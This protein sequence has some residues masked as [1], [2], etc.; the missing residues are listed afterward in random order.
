MTWTK[1]ALIVAA[2]VLLAGCPGAQPRYKLDRAP[3]RFALSA[4]QLTPQE[5]IGRADSIIVGE[6]KAKRLLGQT[7]ITDKGFRVRVW[8]IDL[9]VICQI[10]GDLPDTVRFYFYNY[11]PLV[12][13]Q[14]GNFEY[15]HTT[16][17][18][19]IFFLR[20]EDSL[21]RSVTDLY[22]VTLPFDR[23]ACPDIS[24]YRDR[25]IE[26]QIARLLLTPGE[27]PAKTAEFIR[28]L[29]ESVP[30]AVTVAGFALVNSIVQ[31]LARGHDPTIRRAACLAAYEWLYANPSCLADLERARPDA[32]T[33]ERLQRDREQREYLR[34][35]AGEA[36]RSGGS[37]LLP[38]YSARLGAGFDPNGEVDLLR[39]LATNDDPVFRKCAKQELSRLKATRE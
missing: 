4:I 6:V 19:G 20:R 17:Q 8:E 37:C 22:R 35:I 36:L 15:R 34:R 23:S 9:R 25:P 12:G 13:A 27:D 1:Q 5:A 28:A 38:M 21:V 7:Q 29:P 14:N 31:E 3:S 33:Q 10:K 16:G 24:R 18:R 39:F 26:E 32:S 11:D 2:V 30:D